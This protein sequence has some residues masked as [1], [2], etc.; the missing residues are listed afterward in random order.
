MSPGLLAGLDGPAGF[1]RL[2]GDEPHTEAVFYLTAL[3]FP[4]TRGGARIYRPRQSQ[5]HVFPAHA[6]MSPLDTE[7]VCQVLRF[8]RPRGDEPGGMP[9]CSWTAPFSPPTRG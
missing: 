8:P 9:P 6:G 7:V 4:P 5:P 2:R 3:F 1:P